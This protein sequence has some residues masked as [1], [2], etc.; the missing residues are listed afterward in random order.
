ML[1]ISASN[2][3]P[4]IEGTVELRPL[5]VFVGPNN[6][7]KSYMAML[8]YSLLNQFPRQSSGA[9]RRRWSRLLTASFSEM[10]EQQEVYKGQVFDWANRLSGEPGNNVQVVY[11]DLPD[12][13]KVQIEKA[14]DELVDGYVT[15]S[16][17]RLEHYFRASVSELR[18]N[19]KRKGSFQIALTHAEPH[20]RLGLKSRFG[21]LVDSGSNFD[22]SNIV[23]DVRRELLPVPWEIQ[24]ALFEVVERQ[25]KLP[26]DAY[27]LSELLETVFEQLISTMLQRS[28]RTVHYLPAAR[29]GILHGY[30][31]LAGIVVG[32]AAK[33]GM[34]PLEATPFLGVVSDFVSELLIMEPRNSSGTSVMPEGL[35]AVA[36]HLETT[37][38][39]GE[40]DLHFSEMPYPEIR[41]RSSA[42]DLPL[43]RTSSLVSELAPI[44]LWLK[45][46]VN[47]GDLLILEEPESHLH[48]ASQRRLAEALAMLV[49]RGVQILITTHSDYLLS[50][51]TNLTRLGSLDEMRRN[52][53][54]YGE[55]VYLKAKEIGAY[56]FDLNPDMG[57]T[58]VKELP[59]TV[60]DGIPEDSFNEFVERLY[61][62]SV[63]LQDLT[64]S[65]A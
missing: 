60:R 42:G 51:L 54:G 53:F 32:G 27:L 26:I 9:K 43:A 52:E 29:T 46:V 2:F 6:S 13:L 24:P 31:L 12:F 36:E 20:W 14:I 28:D 65:L 62:E 25:F 47:T 23:T 55:D 1:K 21:K 16:K 30:K 33:T 41:Y 57:G 7:G 17:S 50:Q 15:S 18:R 63:E 34:E 38:L 44:V 11:K 19:T 59:I 40:I 22:M 58:R 37:V 10:F 48:P 39:R 64:S 45:H 8:I 49:R 56:W 3:G 35:L 61:N 4:I 5:T